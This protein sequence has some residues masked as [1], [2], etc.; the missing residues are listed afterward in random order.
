MRHPYARDFLY[1]PHRRRRYRQLHSLWLSLYTVFP[2]ICLSPPADPNQ[3]PPLPIRDS[4]GALYRII[5][6]I[7]DGLR[8]LRAYADDGVLRAT[9]HRRRSGGDDA[10][11]A[12]VAIYISGALR[13]HSAGHRAKGREITAA[14]PPSPLLHFSGR[15]VDDEARW[16]ADIALALRKQ[17]VDVR[18]SFGTPVPHSPDTLRGR[19]R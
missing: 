4:H 3:A 18:T 16:L 12:S 17:V 13:A 11:A 19:G 7:H 15:D 2:E 10:A 8:R 9:E 14:P 5:I 1:W 6:E